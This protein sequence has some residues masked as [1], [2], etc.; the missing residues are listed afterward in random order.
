MLL[1]SLPDSFENFRCAIKSR[2]TLPLPKHLKIKIHDENATRRQRSQT[3]DQAMFARKE[4]LNKR[5]PTNKAPVSKAEDSHFIGT[6][7]FR[8]HRC[9][10]IGHK[11]INC[12]EKTER[13]MK[14]PERKE[15]TTI[16]ERCIVPR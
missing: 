3:D 9:C 5:K 7:K 1:H 4:K 2:D 10:Q 15:K 14:G 8:C 13:S 12:P 6:F 16:I 11:A